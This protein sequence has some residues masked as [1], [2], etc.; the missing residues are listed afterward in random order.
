MLKL[1]VKNISNKRI[2][3]S[4]I[5]LHIKDTRAYQAWVAKFKGSNQS[6]LGY[7]I[8]LDP[9]QKLG[10]G[11]FFSIG[12]NE[13]SQNPI[14][15]TK[16]ISPQSTFRLL[17]ASEAGFTDLQD[18]TLTF[19]ADYQQEAYEIE[20]KFPKLRSENQPSGMITE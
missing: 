4:D 17:L 12:D 16:K 6:D 9:S 2:K 7:K 1:T 15:S 8:Y 10:K 14:I 13:T 18:V 3:I 11:E 19:V 20:V 5:N